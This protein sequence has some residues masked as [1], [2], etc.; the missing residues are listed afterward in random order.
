MKFQRYS[1]L[2]LFILALGLISELSLWAGYKRVNPANAAD[3]M[4][5]Q[6]YELDNGLT[7][8]LTENHE[9]PRFHAEIAVRAGSK[10]DPREST[11][12][13]HYLEHMLFK[14]TDKIG[15]IDYAKEKPHLDRIAELYEEHFKEKNREKRQAIYA[16]INKESQL[17]AQYAIPNEMDKLYKSMGE[18]GL[19]AHTGDEE[20]VYTISLP[21]N[22][23]N[24]WAKIESERFLNPVFRL[25]QPELE[26]VYEEKNR[27]LD[28]KDRIIHYAVTADLYKEHPYGQQTTIGEV[29]HLKNPSLKNMYNFYRTYYV[30]NNMALLISG[31]VRSEETMRVI[32]ENFSVWKRKE[33]PKLRQWEEKPLQG[34]ERVTVKYKGEEYVLLAFRTVGRNHSDAETLKLVD[35]ILNNSVAGLIDLNLNQQQKV[36]QA[37]SSPELQND[38]GAE[39]LFGIPKKGQPLAEVETLLLDQVDLIKQGK[40]DDWIIPA[41]ITDFKKNQKAALESDAARVSL[42]RNS[43]LAIQNWDYTVAEIAR[44]EKLTKADVVRVANRYFGANYV[45][46][47]RLDGQHEVP[48][49]EKPRID[50]ISIDATR[51]SVFARQVLAMPFTQI[52]P[53]FVDPTKDFRITN[54]SDGVKFYYSKN[55]LNDLFSL[56]ISL[57]VGTRQEN[58]IGIAAQLLDRS[59][60]SK[61]NADDLK[62]EFYK[63]G[64]D[65]NIVAG[66]N[67]TT[68]SL[69]GLDESFRRAL[70]LLMDLLKN[71]TADEET[72]KELIQ[73]ILVKR[74]DAKKDYRTISSALSLFNRYGKDSTFLQMLPNAAV[75]KLTREEVLGLIPRLLS[76]KHRLSYTGSLPLEKVVA[77][78]RDVHPVSGPLTEPP[79]YRFLKVQ[80][81]NQTKIL[82]F[83]KEMAQSQVG[84][85]FGN[86][87][88]TEANQ[89]VIQLFND[90]FSGGMGGVV[91]QELREAR[92]LAYGAHAHYVTGDRKGAQNVMIGMIAC[93]ADKT[94]E[95]VEAFI[96][97]ID[98]PP[99][100]PER[101]KESQLAVVN[102]YRVAKLAFREVL[103]A[104]RSWERLGVPIDPRERRFEKIQTTDLEAIFQFQQAHLKSRPK[105]IS[106]VG[107]RKKLNPERL[108]GLGKVTEVKLEDIFVF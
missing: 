50:R 64:A 25:F 70:G 6:I 1:Q 72:F 55:P 22:R 26:I 17:A 35:M 62:K 96:E 10:H 27:T 7:V 107:D 24:Q 93:Q 11:G 101:F 49:I 20:T 9:R 39:Y 48:A 76:Y 30:P 12:L 106:I 63:I 88:Y 28:D 68:V 37:G 71:P 97:L 54:Y 84:I 77:G 87:D 104:V 90:Y 79:P 43:F 81:P 58:R 60:T 83:S 3:P 80:A 14:G 65:F 31:D 95:A 94:P 45:A 85:A 57:D 102:E 78:L 98:H 44:I 29:E 16:E 91:F 23:L 42:M 8:Y 67:E 5:V 100:S 34:A 15:T 69:S 13:A 47:Y 103:G 52:E 89:P 108:A 2:K 92:A 4:A 51:Q 36:R 32:D 74:E 38:Y 59:G 19:N 33:I 56:S 40:F 46:G 82:F 61:F 75:Q 21:A 73:I 86:D 105:L 66:E 18:S 53:V 41:I 99:K